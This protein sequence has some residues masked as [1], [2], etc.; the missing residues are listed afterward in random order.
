MIPVFGLLNRK[1]N[2]A[3]SMGYLVFQHPENRRVE[4]EVR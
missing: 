4:I 1:N 2:I 3:K